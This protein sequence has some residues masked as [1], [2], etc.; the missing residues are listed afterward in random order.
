MR[1]LKGV[2]SMKSSLAR[3][4]RVSL[5]AALTATATLQVSAD[6]TVL[7]SDHGFGPIKIGM[8][9]KEVE[10]AAHQRLQPVDRRVF[11]DSCWVTHFVKNDDRPGSLLYFVFG[12]G[13]LNVIGIEQGNPIA[14]TIHTTE[15][16]GFA[17]TI[18]DIKRA[19]RSKFEMHWYPYYE[20]DN[21][22]HWIYVPNFDKS[23]VIIFETDHGKVVGI[24]LGVTHQA[25][26]M[27]DCL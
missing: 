17:S 13:R 10:R 21:N 2:R 7:I 24:R 12:S 15:G 14:K 19:Y 25:E 18:E 1:N 11:D 20:E 3:V 23:K 26:S 9:V 5:L 4:L 22:Y 8:T 16:I 6:D 27:E